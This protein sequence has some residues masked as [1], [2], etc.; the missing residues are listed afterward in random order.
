MRNVVFVSLLLLFSASSLSAQDWRNRRYEPYRDNGIALTVF[1]GYRYGGTIFA[2]TSN[3]FSRDVDVK[4]AANYGIN[5]GIPVSRTG[6][7]V[8][9]LVDRQDT[10]FIRGDGLFSPNSNLG[11]FHVTYYQAGLFV[12][13]GNSRN[14]T[15]YV[16]VSAGMANLDPDINGVSASNRFAASAAIGLSVPLSRNLALR[17]EE[18]GY[19]TS[20]QDNN[21]CNRCYYNNNRD[22]YQG[23][24]NFGVS[25]KF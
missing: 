10:N 12:P 18:R 17:V 8:E 23:E 24:T 21:G 5:L 6:M 19:V 11:D 4:S 7:K 1:G 16:A 20:M 2:D 22:L 9:L 14:A 25:F 15:P 13:F 3:L